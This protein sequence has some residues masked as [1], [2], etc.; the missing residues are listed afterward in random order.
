MTTCLE[1]GGLFEKPQKLKQHEFPAEFC[2]ETNAVRW[3][4]ERATNVKRQSSIQ[5]SGT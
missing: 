1:A 2:E 3:L 4:F 5:A